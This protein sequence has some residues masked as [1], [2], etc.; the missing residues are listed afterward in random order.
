M[1]RPKPVI[2]WRNA[3]RKTHAIGPAWAGR[4]E[5]YIP[6]SNNPSLPCPSFHD[7]ADLSKIVQ[8]PVSTD[9]ASH[10]SSVCIS[11][12]NSYVL[13]ALTAQ[14]IFL[15]FCRELFCIICSRK[16]PTNF[17]PSPEFKKLLVT[18]YETDDATTITKFLKE[19]CRTKT[20]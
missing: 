10:H 5:R 17:S 14:Q 9:F 6:K 12:S 3:A 7:F 8:H 20:K 4:P 15:L 18:F 19:K 2:D 16:F 13:N 1:T 11:I